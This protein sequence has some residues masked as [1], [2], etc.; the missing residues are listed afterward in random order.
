[1]TDI[2]LILTYLMISVAVLACIVSPILKMKNNPSS[3][4][5]TV[6]PVIGLTVIIVLSI[7]IASGEVLPN[8]TDS[9]G[10]MISSS[11]S[12]IIGGSLITFYILSVVTIGSVL[13]SEFIYKIF[14]NGKK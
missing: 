6:L 11:M 5:K 4:K 13:Y 9:S 12:K 10:N 8:Y 3:M 1:M 14:K 2:G 7:L